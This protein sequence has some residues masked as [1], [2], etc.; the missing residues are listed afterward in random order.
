MCRVWSPSGWICWCPIIRPERHDLSRLSSV[1]HI[2]RFGSNHVCKCY[3]T[4]L[5]SFTA[6]DYVVYSMWLCLNVVNFFCCCYEIFRFM[7]HVNVL[8]F[9]F[10]LKTWPKTN[11]CVAHFVFWLPAF[12]F[13]GLCGW[14]FG[15][16]VYSVMK[17]CF[18]FLTFLYFMIFYS[19]YA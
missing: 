12:A 9:F 16:H 19:F 14:L 6:V 17:R 7:W 11:F 2:L 18:F 1:N 3:Q 10:S 8:N 4:P 15:S 5:D 13:I